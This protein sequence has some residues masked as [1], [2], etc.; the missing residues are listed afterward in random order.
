MSLDQAKIVSNTKK[1]FETAT[2]NGF[3]N[4]ELI[5]F[6]G[7]D[8]IKAPA[9]S[10]ADYHNA[11]EGGLIDHLLKVAS[12]AVKINNTLPEDEKVDQTS[13]LKVCLLH[14]IGKAKLYKPCTSEWHIKKGKMY[15]FNED[16]V[17]MR[18]GERSVYYI[19]S[20]GIKITE[21]EFSAI[22]FFD[23][24]DDKMSDYHN[25]MLGDLLKMG[26]ILA[27]KHAKIKNN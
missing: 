27:I 20:H 22:L 13:L 21:E 16:L 26:N 15:E 19:L 17:S 4:D 25:S 9:S 6:L 12:Y 14:G 8:F 7:E 2:N 11:F 23:K 10:M 18:I 1:Y 5:Q 3:M 24:V